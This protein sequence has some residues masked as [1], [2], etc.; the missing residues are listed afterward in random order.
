MQAIEIFLILCLAHL[1]SDFLLQTDAMVKAKKHGGAAAYGRHGLIHYAAIVV[2]TVFAYPALLVSVR[3]QAVCVALIGAHLLIDF[4]KERLT[5]AAKIRDNALTF[6]TD[7]AA[8]IVTIVAAALLFTG[9]SPLAVV[10]RLAALVPHR[11]EILAVLVIYFAVVFA[12]TRSVILL[13][14]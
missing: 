9:T 6:L 8:H 12:A 13:G 1:A 10:E 3:F 4:C 14:R 5:A 2:V 7:Q 11:D